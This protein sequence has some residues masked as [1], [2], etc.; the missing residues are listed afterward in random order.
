MDNVYIYQAKESNLSIFCNLVSILFFVISICWKFCKTMKQQNVWKLKICDTC[1]ARD[2]RLSKEGWGFK[3]VSRQTS[4]VVLLHFF[5]CSKAFHFKLW[6]FLHLFPF[7]FIGLWNV[8][9]VVESF[10]RLLWHGSCFVLC[11]MLSFKL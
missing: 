4:F 1:C 7:I 10:E 5:E 9:I 8:T 6:F 3:F 11:C 2:N